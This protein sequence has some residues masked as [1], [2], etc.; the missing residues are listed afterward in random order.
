MN[1]VVDPNNDTIYIESIH[2]FKV[3]KQKEYKNN[4]EGRLDLCVEHV[5][6]LSSRGKCRNRS[7]NK[8][9]WMSCN[10]LGFLNNEV[11]WEAAGNW[12]VDFGK[13]NKQERQRVVIKKI[14]HADSLTESIDAASQDPEKH[15]VFC[16][17]F[18]MTA[19][20]EDGTLK[21]MV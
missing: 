19:E 5:R 14:R 9:K 2:P 18:L 21:M 11:Y 1:C 13:M 6:L 10:C 7:N 16:L 17:P 4:D 15:L 20:P 3:F 8:K 12:M